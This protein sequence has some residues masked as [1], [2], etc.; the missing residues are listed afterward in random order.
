MTSGRGFRDFRP[1]SSLQGVCLFNFLRLGLG[2]VTYTEV[3]QGKMLQLLRRSF[4]TR[5]TPSGCELSWRTSILWLV[6]QTCISKE[7]QHESNSCQAQIDRMPSVSK[8]QDLPLF[9]RIFPNVRPIRTDGMF[10]RAIKHGLCKCAKAFRVAES[11]N[12]G[13]P[14]TGPH[15]LLASSGPNHFQ[16]LLD[17]WAPRNLS[18][19]SL[20]GEFLP[21]FALG[22]LFPRNALEDK[23]IGM[24]TVFDGKLDEAE[25]VPALAQEPQAP[26]HFG[27]H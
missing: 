21:L 14:P 3:A 24:I 5:A 15:C 8:V 26:V 2:G 20:D 4:I 12:Q 6:Y 27:P 18:V 7:K 16:Y 11:V 22:C 17:Q 13:I 23:E 10:S 19:P 25:L 9:H 1:V